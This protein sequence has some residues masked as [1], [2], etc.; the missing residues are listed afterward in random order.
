[1][2]STCATPVGA[3]WQRRPAR[4]WTGRRPRGRV[5]SAVWYPRGGHLRVFFGCSGASLSLAHDR[6]RPCAGHR[7]LLVPVE[8]E[9]R[10]GST[11]CHPESGRAV[12]PWRYGGSIWRPSRPCAQ[13][14]DRAIHR[15]REV[16][17]IGHALPASLRVDE[18]PEWPARANGGGGRGSKD[19]PSWATVC[20]LHFYRVAARMVTATRS[21]EQRS[22]GLV[23]RDE[24][25]DD[26]EQQPARATTLSSRRSESRPPV[27]RSARRRPCQPPGVTEL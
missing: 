18:S 4:L 2:A 9:A 13:A 19:S 27:R 5:E 23:H 22:P 26:R 12:A 1:M 25:R 11:I 17:P 16:E 15:G 24:R 10:G 6:Q 3:R 20:V 21:Y 7:R 8:R 14:R